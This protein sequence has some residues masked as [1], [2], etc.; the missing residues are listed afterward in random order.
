MADCKKNTNPLARGGYNQQQ[1]RLQGIQPGYIKVDERNFE[2]WLDFARNF[3]RFIKYYNNNYE[4]DGN[5]QPFFDTDVSAQLANIAVQ[6]VEDYRLSLKS[7]FSSLQS[8]DLKNN[9]PKLK[10]NLGL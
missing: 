10:E 7:L 8:K 1:R 4:V 9:E 6:D 5:W 3:A 2:H